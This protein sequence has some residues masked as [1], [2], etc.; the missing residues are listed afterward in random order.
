MSYPD[1]AKRDGDPTQD[2]MSQKKVRPHPALGGKGPDSTWGEN[3][4]NKPRDGVCEIRSDLFLYAL[5]CLVF[6][7]LKALFSRH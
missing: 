7:H 1:S 2:I 3:F 6:K 5:R 4:L